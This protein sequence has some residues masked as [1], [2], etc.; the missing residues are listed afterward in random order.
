MHACRKG[1]H[2]SGTIALPGGHLEYGEGL[3][4]RVDNYFTCAATV[5]IM[6]LISSGEGFEECAAREVLEETGI[7]LDKDRITFAYATTDVFQDLQRQ[8]VTVGSSVCLKCWLHNK[9]VL[10][11]QC[12]PTD[13]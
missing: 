2:G 7:T 8:Y 13:L 9:C 4:I 10:K 1:S 12:L 11:S 5:N 6:I 3:R